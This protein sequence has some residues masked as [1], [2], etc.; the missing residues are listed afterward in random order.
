MTMRALT[1]AGRAI[2]YASIVSYDVAHHAKDGTVAK[3][4]KEREELLTPL[5]KAFP[6]ERAMEVTNLGI[7][8]H[9]GMGFV[10]ETGAA[11]FY[12]DARIAAI[13]EGTTGIQAIDLVGRKLG[14]ESGKLA[15]DF[16]TEAEDLAGMLANSGSDDLGSIGDSLGLTAAGLRETT[17]FMVGAMGQDPE[18]GLTGATPYLDQFGYVAGGFYL[19]KSALAATGMAMSGEDEGYHRDRIAVARFYAE[20][21]LPRANGLVSAVMAGG[22]TLPSPESKLFAG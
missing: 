19:A 8:I 17:D 3:A 7:Q 16:I 6:S 22:E 2:C 1:D 15:Y 9:G 10:E 20:N 12:R 11:Q 13:Y 5:A 14:M 21:L 4:A 18:S